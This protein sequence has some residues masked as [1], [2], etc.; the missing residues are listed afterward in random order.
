[1]HAESPDTLSVPVQSAVMIGQEQVSMWSTTGN[2]CSGQP[3]GHD[4][5]PG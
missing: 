2:L 4:I 5:W 3:L 1:M